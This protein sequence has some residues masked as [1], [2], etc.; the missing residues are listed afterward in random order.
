MAENQGGP[1]PRIDEFLIAEYQHFADSFWRTEELGEKRLN[2]FISLL[3]AA[4]AGLILLATS[5]SSFSTSDV[6]WIAF[7]TGIALLLLGLS[8]LLRMLRR[9]DV[10]DQYKDAMDLVRSNFCDRYRLI[11]YKPFKKLPRTLFTGGLA[12]T[13]ALM[14]SMIAAAI[15]AI[16]FLFVVSETLLVVLGGLAFLAS[17]SVQFLYIGRRHHGGI[18]RRDERG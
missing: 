8:T 15:T 13:A 2:F 3:T 12:Q 4:V 9:N 10:A 6:Q 1:D 14:N 16:G 5:E 17:L 18:R 7:F 11:D